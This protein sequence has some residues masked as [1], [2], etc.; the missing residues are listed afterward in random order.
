MKGLLRRLRGAIGMGLTW[1]VGWIPVGAL[2]GVGLSVVGVEPAGLLGAAGM[3]AM[4]FGGL[5]FI[6][7]GIFSV[8]LRLADGRRRFDQLSLPRFT[9]LGGLGGLLLGGVAGLAVF[10][11]PG[12]QVVDAV[13][14]GII[15]L[16]GAG[17]AAGTLALARAADNT[18]LPAGTDDLERAGLSKA[19]RE[20]LLGDAG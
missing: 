12:P 4:V 6:G 19:E 17:S 18:A 10:G 1:A 15:T 9:V 3:G 20:H 14:V 5:G 8:L 16:L 2:F 7:G 13:F 11:S